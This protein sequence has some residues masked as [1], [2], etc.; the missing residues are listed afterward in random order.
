MLISI[1]GN[2]GMAQ[3][4]HPEFRWFRPVDTGA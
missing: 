4:S 1:N 2:G 3:F